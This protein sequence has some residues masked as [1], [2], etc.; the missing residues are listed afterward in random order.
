MHFYNLINK[1]S[2][3]EKIIIY[4]DMDGVI[5]SYDFGNPLDFLNKR[6]LIT[7]IKTLEKVS[8]LKNVELH[9]LSV[10]RK[11]KEVKDKNDWLDK[12][13]KFF[14]K[15]KR[16]ILDKESN[17]SFT[18]KELKLNYLK[19]LNYNDKIIFI[20]DDNEVLYFIKDN[21]KGIIL[22]QDSEL[23]D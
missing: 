19:T 13:A 1:L 16:I 23:I 5:A 9:I 14:E 22:F 3:D 18:S 7:N 8:H 6:P 11:K 2:K 21:L 4:V 10:C 20:D 12:Y 15:D 17:H